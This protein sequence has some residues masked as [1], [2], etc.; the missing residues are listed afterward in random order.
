VVVVES[1]SSPSVRD[2]GSG[3]V[4]GVPGAATA[5][6]TDVTAVLGGATAVDDAAVLGGTTPVGVTDVLGDATTAVDVTAFLGDAATAVDDAAVLGGT[7]AVDE[8][9][10]LGGTTAVD[11][12]AVLGGATAVDETAV[13]GGVPKSAIALSAARA[14][15]RIITSPDQL[16][17]GASPQ[18]RDGA[19]WKRVPA[20]R[21]DLVW[22]RPPTAPRTPGSH[23]APR[24]PRAVVTVG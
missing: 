8:A 19:C 1:G 16:V 9:A 17:H 24:G 14:T 4:V 6:A 22:V 10:V 2:A 18:R 3:T 11:E 20:F 21:G 12:A 13:S 5:T 15:R 7:T 23:T